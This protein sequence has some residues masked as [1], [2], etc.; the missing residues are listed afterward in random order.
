MKYIQSV[1][2][3]QNTDGNFPS[4]IVFVFIDFLVVFDE[5]KEF[6]HLLP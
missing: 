2:I 1:N 6:D 5:G 4:V 3:I